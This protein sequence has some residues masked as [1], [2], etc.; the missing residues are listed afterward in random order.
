MCGT[1][2][3][4]ESKSSPEKSLISNNRFYGAVLEV[5]DGTVE[6]QYDSHE[7]VEVTKPFDMLRFE[8]SKQECNEDF[9][10]SYWTQCLMDRLILIGV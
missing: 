5:V 1:Y 9:Y 2:R 8:T 3:K 4:Y 6:L 10:R 7:E